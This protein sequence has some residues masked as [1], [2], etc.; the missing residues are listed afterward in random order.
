LKNSAKAAKWEINM[1]KWEYIIL[2]ATFSNNEWRAKFQ[3]GKEISGWATD[4]LGNYLSGLGDQG[5]ELVSVTYTTQT[6]QSA[7]TV[8]SQE[9]SYKEWYRLFLKRAKE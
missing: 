2:G 4:T 5:W 1:Q 6:T 3:N 8:S 7:G 9:Y